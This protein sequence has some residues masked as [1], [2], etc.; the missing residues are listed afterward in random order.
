M[1]QPVAFMNC[2]FFHE[3]TA[4]YIYVGA[5]AKKNIVTGQREQK[6]GSLTT[7]ARVHLHTYMIN[8]G[9]FFF[10]FSTHTSWWWI[11]N[12]SSS[13]PPC[14]WQL[15]SQFRSN[16]IQNRTPTSLILT[17]SQITWIWFKECP[18]WKIRIRHIL[19]LRSRI[20]LVW[21][22]FLISGLQTLTRLA[23]STLQEKHQSTT[24][25]HNPRSGARSVLRLIA[26]NRTRHRISR[27]NASVV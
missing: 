5:F 9:F 2:R 20:R 1:K 10:F 7:W 21:P 16:S 24:P 23:L 6:H 11:F 15:L 22:K 26:A 25:K 27:P 19:A 13:F 17:H 18:P 4:T 12:S 14:L 3:K 8:N